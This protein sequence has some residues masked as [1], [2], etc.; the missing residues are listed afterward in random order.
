MHGLHV[1]C[2]HEPGRA[3]PLSIQI[4]RRSSDGA[5]PYREADAAEVVRLCREGTPAR[6]R[7]EDNF[8]REMP[9]PGGG[10]LL[11]K[12]GD[13]RTQRA[14]YAFQ[15]LERVHCAV[16]QGAVEALATAR[17]AA[18]GERL[19]IAGAVAVRSNGKAFLLAE[20]VESLD[21]ELPRDEPPW[22]V[23]VLWQGK[24]LMQIGEPSDHRVIAP[25]AHRP[26]AAEQFWV[27]LREFHEAQLTVNGHIIRAELADT[28][29][30]RSY[31]AQGR[32]GFDA[33]CGMLFYFPR[34]T[35][36][37]MVMKSVSFPLSIA[38]IRADGTIANIESLQPGS[39]REAAS[40][41]SVNYVL[42]MSEGWFREHGVSPGDR[43]LIR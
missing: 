30:A 4:A 37:V 25:C 38:F 40:R 17:R 26:E 14:V 12:T 41:G 6:V 9:L 21:G 27:R 7:F 32:T 34:R 22:D 24:A 3:A 15:T 42:E 5:F 1:N 39:S 29:A 16:G 10:P 19:R 36:P 31:G 20:E 43:I 11:L 35:R 13:G 33:D 2:T 23:A 18:L 28:P 8:Q